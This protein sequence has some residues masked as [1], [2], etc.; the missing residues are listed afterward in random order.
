MI[1]GPAAAYAADVREQLA[2]RPAVA[3]QLVQTHL[4]QDDWQRVSVE[5]LEKPLTTRQLMR[6]AAWGLQDLPPEGVDRLRRGDSKGPVLILM[7]RLL[8]RRPFQRRVRRAFRYA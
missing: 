7:W 5:Y 6:V 2:E 3:L 4:S 8:L 1:T